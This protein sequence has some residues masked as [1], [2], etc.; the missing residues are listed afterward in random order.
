M[1]LTHRATMLACYNGYITQAICINLAPLFYLT[2]Q[3]QF[4]LSVTDLSIL[5]AVNFTTQLLVD[6]LSSKFAARMDLR[7]FT[8]LAHILA[9][10]G[11]IGLSLFPML[12]PPYAGLLIAV[13]LLGMGGGFTEVTISPLI[14]ACPTEGKSG[15]MSLLHSFYCWGQ[16]GVVLFSGIYFAFFEIETS[17]IY[18]PYLWAIVPTVGA[19]AFCLVPIYRLPADEAGDSGAGKL[20]RMPIFLCFL[21]LMFCAGAAEMIMSQWASAFAESALQIPKELGDLLGPCMFALMMGTS[22]LL[23]GRFSDRINRHRIMLYACILCGVSYLLAAFS[24]VPVLSLAGCALCG[25]GVG[26]FWPGL[27][28]RASATVPAGGL[29][30]FA[31]LALA[32]D[33]GC[34]VGP[35][36]AGTVSDLFGNLRAGFCF[37]VLFPL[38]CFAGLI[39]QHKTKKRSAK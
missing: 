15:S 38:I 5:I 11:L 20:F 35:S 32:G 12:M 14:E 17:W 22:R 21:L 8:V 30:M 31:L 23:Y 2:F 1:K 25:F 3:N 24:P 29:S 36:A 6:I 34:L 9:A 33:V 4:D 13:A 27:L 19:V 16:A 28:S 10:V 18:L 39:I 7:F 37:A 26:I